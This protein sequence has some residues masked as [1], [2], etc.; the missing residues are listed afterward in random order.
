MLRILA[1]KVCFS[2]TDILI[3]CP[4]GTERMPALF[5]ITYP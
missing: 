4:E 3:E 5:R 2:V 1:R